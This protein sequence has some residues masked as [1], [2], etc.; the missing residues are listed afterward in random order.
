MKESKTITKD[1]V[2][3]MTVDEVTALHA[4][5]NEVYICSMHPEVRSDKLGKCPLCGMH[6][7]EKK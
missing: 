5:R 1:P 4:E 2:C 7:V 3:G 6:L